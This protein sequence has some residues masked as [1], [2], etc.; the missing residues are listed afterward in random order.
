MSAHRRI[1]VCLGAQ[2]IAVVLCEHGVIVDQAHE[3]LVDD[4]V[5]S[6]ALNRCLA[7]VRPKRTWRRIACHVALEPSMA[8]VKR[9][10]DV[11]LLRSNREQL[12]ML[13]LVIGEHFLGSAASLTLVAGEQDRS[14]AVWVLAVNRSLLSVIEAETLLAGLSLRGVAPVVDL[15]A[16]TAP[17]GVTT[18]A[19]HDAAGITA[20]GAVQ[21]GQLTD[22]WRAAAVTPTSRSSDY[23]V[24]PSAAAH[25]AALAPTR[26]RFPARTFRATSRQ[27]RSVP[28]RRLFAIAACLTLAAAVA[29]GLRANRAA[30]RTEA[31]VRRLAPLVANAV[32][33]RRGVD[34]LA[35]LENQVVQFRAS[36][37]NALRVL[38]QLSETLNDASYITSLSMDS[39]S[40][41][42]TF[43]APSATSL[44]EAFST[45][46]AFDSVTIVGAISRSFLPPGMQP[47]G[48]PGQVQTAAELR[49]DERIALRFVTRRPNAG[50]EVPSR[51]DPLQA[52]RPF[53]AGYSIAPRVDRK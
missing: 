48:T 49:S 33:Q 23:S 8:Q 22:V 11:P 32:S 2:T 5:I 1:G 14:G 40:A 28:L 51:T 19:R 21:N 6:D 50:A 29:P 20:F 26:S 7:S 53:A 45:S 36:G 9:I 13:S 4:S 12:S 27:P 37:V 30:N 10:D 44:M 39:V 31:E 43:A 41:Q 38:S 18:V 52:R 16:A 17:P 42:A 24:E 46:A 3:T 15:L 47:S 25:L 35:R 34:S